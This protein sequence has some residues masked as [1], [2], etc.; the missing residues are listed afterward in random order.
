MAQGLCGR[1]L[2]INLSN[3]LHTLDLLRAK[4]PISGPAKQVKCSISSLFMAALCVDEW[5]ADLLDN[6]VQI[7]VVIRRSLTN[8]HHID[9]GGC[10]V[11]GVDDPPFC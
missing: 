10:F 2:A 7:T 11:N 4:T 6:L 5:L 8:S 9:G 3:D 1:R